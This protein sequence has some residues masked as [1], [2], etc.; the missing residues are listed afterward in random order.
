[1]LVPEGPEIFLFFFST[2]LKEMPSDSVI[3]FPVRICYQTFPRNPEQRTDPI[4]KRHYQI[5]LNSSLRNGKNP[6]RFAITP[7]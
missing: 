3:S 2:L 4:Q 5:L 1:M 7:T 6:F